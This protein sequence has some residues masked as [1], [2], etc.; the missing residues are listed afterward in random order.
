MAMLYLFLVIYSLYHKENSGK[1]E[2]QFNRSRQLKV[3]LT[4]DFSSQPGFLNNFLNNFLIDFL[5]DF[6]TDFGIVNLSNQW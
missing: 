6:L 5:I 2:S 1:F 3:P 4:L